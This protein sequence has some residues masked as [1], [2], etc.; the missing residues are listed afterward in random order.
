MAEVAVA[1]SIFTELLCPSG[2]II[3]RTLLLRIAGFVVVYAT[4]S[5]SEGML[6]GMHALNSDTPMQSHLANHPIHTLFQ[7]P[8]YGC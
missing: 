6:Y 2:A 5:Q 1:C 8:M 3:Q 4:P 7:Q